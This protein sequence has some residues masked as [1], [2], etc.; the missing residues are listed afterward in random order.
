MTAVRL[1]GGCERYGN[2]G[3]DGHGKQARAEG[4]HDQAPCSSM[5]M[6]APKSGNMVRSCLNDGRSP[7]DRLPHHPADALGLTL[8]LDMDARDGAAQAS[9]L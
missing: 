9:P 5:M 1:G 2:T 8:Q 7:D 3:D 6:A 4:L